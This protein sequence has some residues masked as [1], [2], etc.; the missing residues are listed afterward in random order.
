MKYGLQNI[1]V[2]SDSEGGISCFSNFAMSVY[3]FYNQKVYIYYKKLC[4]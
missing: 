3:H 1:N 2:V 4:K